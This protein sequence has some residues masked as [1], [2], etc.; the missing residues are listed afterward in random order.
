MYK[1]F[2]IL[3][4]YWEMW[5]TVS[6]DVVIKKQM[7]SIMVWINLKVLDSSEAGG[8]FHWEIVGYCGWLL[9]SVIGIMTWHDRYVYTKLCINGTLES[10]C[11]LLDFTNYSNMWSRECSQPSVIVK[12]LEEKEKNIQTLTSKLTEAT[13]ALEANEKLLRDVN[14]K[15]LDSKSA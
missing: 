4:I 11:L 5:N 13:E 10:W 15:V 3:D 8:N 9:W 1:R 6:K 7:D 14:S 12:A 2:G